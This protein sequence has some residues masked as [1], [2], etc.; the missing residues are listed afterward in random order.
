MHD[1]HVSLWFDHDDPEKSEHKR[2]WHLRTCF[3]NHCESRASRVDIR[4]II[5]MWVNASLEAV[6]L[7]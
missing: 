2:K 4:A 7:S 6:V 1:W 3:E 5:A